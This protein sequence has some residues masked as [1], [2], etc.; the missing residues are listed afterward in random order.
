MEMRVQVIAEHMPGWQT[1]Q[2][3]ARAKNALTRSRDKKDS[4]KEMD[5]H[6]LFCERLHEIAAEVCHAKPLELFC[7]FG[8]PQSVGYATH[9]YWCA[10]MLALDQCDPG[11]H[12]GDGHK[13]VELTKV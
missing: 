13:W 10:L 4:K 12:S 3:K 11:S 1:E 9:F 6:T 2:V 5:A 7:M 8:Q